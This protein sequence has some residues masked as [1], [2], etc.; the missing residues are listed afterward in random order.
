MNYYETLGVNHTTTPA[1]IKQA[2][3][4]LASKHHPDKGGDEAEF[5]KIREAYDV[6]SDPQKKAEYDSPKPE[7]HRYN[8]P[9]F[10]DMFSQF[11]NNGRRPQARN[12]DAVCDV[13]VSLNDIYRGLEKT[14]DLGYSK[15]KMI[16]PA[17]T[18]HGTQFNLQGKGPRN[19]PGSDPGDLIVRVH[20][21]N[22]PEWDR[23]RDD[24]F[25]RVQ[26]DYF[27]AMIGTEVEIVHLN[28]N[29]LRI[30][31]PKRTAPGSRLKLSGFGMPN[32]NNGIQGN[33]YVVVDVNLPSLT[34]TQIQ[35]LQ[36]FV[37]K[38]M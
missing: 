17:G 31:I 22:P 34:D 13:S 9:N 18:R 4:K 37:N 30:K 2:Y 8:P 25:I 26:V 7:W 6:L 11:F 16:I 27:Q 36:D 32:P 23:E 1:E 38:E 28:N 15:L 5:K 21:I 10:D 35:K 12:H 19:N 3:R 14:L 33:L 24:L 20:V 29:K